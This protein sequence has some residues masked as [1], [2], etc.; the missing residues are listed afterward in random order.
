MSL[1][2]V[3]TYFNQAG[4]VLFETD[5]IWSRAERRSSAIWAALRSLKYMWEDVARERALEIA[6]VSVF[7]TGYRKE[8]LF[9]RSELVAALEEPDIVQAD[10]LEKAKALLL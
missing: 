2:I 8:H 4:D 7:D 10:V 3:C 1:P 9:S 5:A 6:S